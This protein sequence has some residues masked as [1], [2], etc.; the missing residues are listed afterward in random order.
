MVKKSIPISIQNSIE[1]AITQSIKNSWLT[2]PN[3]SN[4]VQCNAQEMSPEVMKKH[5]DLYVNDFSLDMGN[6]GLEA[7]EKMREVLHFKN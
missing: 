2:Y 6:I 3:L 4:F 7:I 5:I 1:N